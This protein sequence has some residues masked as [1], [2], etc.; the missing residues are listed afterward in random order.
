M[1]GP[2]W[3][4]CPH[5]TPMLT[6]IEGQASARKLR[7][8]GVACC[9]RV[10]HLLGHGACRG[11]EQQALSRQ[12]V[13]VAERFA[14]GLASA[15]DL[16]RAHGMA[17]LGNN[18]NPCLDSI[19]PVT[20]G[21]S[22]FATPRLMEL[23]CRFVASELAPQASGMVEEFTRLASYAVDGADPR[24]THADLGREVFGNPF[25]RVAFDPAWLRC[26]DGAIPGLAR[27]IY[28][29]RSFDQLPVLADALEDAGCQDVAILDHCRR[30]ANHVRGCW[31]L[32]KL[33]GKEEIGRGL[34]EIACL[35]K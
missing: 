8:F 13:E 33:L 16:A 26:D 24:P 20:P 11:Q 31:A 18:V 5:P 27:A 25:H 21:S 4:T 35:P 7:L 2:E 32:D 19:L 12:A 1:T 10:L 29:D 3:L 34:S 14:D 28:A 22:R 17:H 30:P 23:A 15:S 9:R 6:F